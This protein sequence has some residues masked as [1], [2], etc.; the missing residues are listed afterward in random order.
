MKKISFFLFL[1]LRI[2]FFSQEKQVPAITPPEQMQ[3]PLTFSILDA[4]TSYYIYLEHRILN[5]LNHGTVWSTFMYLES[6][7][8][9]RSHARESETPEQC[10]GRTGI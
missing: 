5:S 8:L 4:S 1:L 7:L 9:L 3:T 2:R 10:P 6:D